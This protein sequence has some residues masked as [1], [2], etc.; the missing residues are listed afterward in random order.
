MHGGD[1][2]LIV[3]GTVLLLLIAAAAR[4]VTNRTRVPLSVFLFVIGIVLAAVGEQMGAA[5]VLDRFRLSPGLV[6]YVFLPSL[7]F[8]SAISLDVR[9]LKRNLL[10][11]LTLA[12]PGLLLSTTGI[13]AVVALATPLSFRTSLLLGAILS[14]TDPVAVIAI[15]ERL[16]APRRLHV[17]VEGESLFNDATSLVVSRIIATVVIGGTVSG[18]LAVAGL[19]EFAWV[20]AGGVGAGAL[21][22][23]ATGYLLR[24]VRTDSFVSITLT[25][26]LAYLSFIIAEELLGVSGVMATVTAGLTFSGWGWM[27]VSHD[28]RDYLEY[29]WQYV[30][31]V[32]NALIFLLVGLLVEPESLARAA[33]ILIWVV[34]GM[35]AS[36][37]LVAYGLVPSLRLIGHQYAFNLRYRTVLFWG[38]LRGAVAVAIVLSLPP[39]G[40]NDLFLTLVI[41]A[42]LFTLIVHGLSID[43]LVRLLG[44]DKPSPPDRFIRLDTQLQARRNALDWLPEIAEGGRF[45]SSILERVREDYIASV[46]ALED[47]LEEIRAHAE[48]RHEQERMLYLRSLGE[49]RGRYVELF[50]A[51]HIGERALRTLD[52]EVSLQ[53]DA[54]RHAERLDTLQLGRFHHTPLAE[55]L[56]RFVDGLPPLKPLAERRRRRR[57]ATDYELSWAHY[58]SSGHV[59]ERLSAETETFPEDVVDAVAERYRRWNRAAR[60]QLDTAAEQFPEFVA[61]AQ[62]R[63]G[64]RLLLLRER[65]FIE[66]ATEQ[67]AMPD[68]AGAECIA[69]IDTRLESLRSREIAELGVAPKQLLRK[70]PLLDALPEDAFEELADQLRSR[71]FPANEVI[72]RQ[73]ESGTSLFLIARG[74]VRVSREGDGAS[75]ELSTLL[76]G[77]FVGEMALL[78]EEPRTATVYA[79][80]PVLAYELRGQDARAAMQ[81][82]PTMLDALEEADRRRRE[83][84]RREKEAQE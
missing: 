67:G 9:E 68:T 35:L 36:R 84:A 61:E 57:F 3:G 47:E 42:V 82:H 75:R 70:I 14:A 31:F 28:V 21:L 6:L 27:R 58:Q 5:A 52:L 34:L 39:F 77:D 55:R 65:G 2:S 63:F 60:E 40:Q 29:F 66:E 24:G 50:D 33:P 62:E 73:G 56:Q 46:G 20:F 41:G 80:T 79:V 18:N 32:A 72:I 49:E 37:V 25:T 45:S 1:V 53:L 8:E 83:E 19:V 10:P 12:V 30:A 15:F 76:P 4:V 78:H 64:L 38:G 44:L 43:P 48:S 7:I 26:I 74:V 16:G 69:E 13:A 81:T 17:L 59:L 71:T 11:I 23:F 22:G 54:V 51:G